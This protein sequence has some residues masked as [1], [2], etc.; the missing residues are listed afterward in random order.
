MTVIS[1]DPLMIIYYPDRYK[2]QKND[3]A[4]DDCLTALKHIPDWFVT[5]II[6]EKF[7]DALLAND[8]ILLFD[9]DFSKVT[10]F[11]ND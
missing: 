10:V 4:V 2:T 1:K 8:D 11:A 7:H 9:E 6:L 3:E 5:S